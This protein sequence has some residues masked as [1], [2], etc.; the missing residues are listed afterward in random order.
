M[1]GEEEKVKSREKK[2][3]RW[4]ERGGEDENRQIENLKSLFIPCVPEEMQHLLV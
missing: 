4:S 3:L 2:S 1:D